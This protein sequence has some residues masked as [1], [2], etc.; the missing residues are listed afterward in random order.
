[1]NE[2]FYN[3]CSEMISH[4]WVTQKCHQGLVWQGETAAVSQIISHKLLLFVIVCCVH[5]RIVHLYFTW[6]H[7]QWAHDISTAW[8]ASLGSLTKWFPSK[9]KVWFCMNLY[10]ITFLHAAAQD[11]AALLNEVH[12]ALFQEVYS[13]S[14]S[15]VFSETYKLFAF[16][17]RGLPS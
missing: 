6:C 11:H 7:W 12:I 14:I 17:N 5:C 15:T 9:A 13:S 1:M 16:N 10:C 4:Q 3:T 2:T 8:N